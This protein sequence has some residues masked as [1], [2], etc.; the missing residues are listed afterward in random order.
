MKKVISILKLALLLSLMSLAFTSSSM[1][2]E[3]VKDRVLALPGD[4]YIYFDS[5]ISASKDN[6]YLIG[7]AQSDADKNAETFA[8]P[9]G[10]NL[11]IDGKPIKTLSF[12]F[13][14]KD[15]II[16]GVPAH[17]WYFYHTFEAGYFQPNTE[18]TFGFE[19]FWYN[20]YGWY[21]DGGSVVFRQIVAG[22]VFGLPF[23]VSD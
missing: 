9:I 5:T 19:Y 8:R 13:N 17:W 14:D 6:V 22:S 15:G 21:N 18:H 20:G 10:V 7:I 11:Y 12:S 4:Q 3:G 23:H 1:A 2:N 16:A